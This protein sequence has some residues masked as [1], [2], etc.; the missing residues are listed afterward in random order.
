MLS[1]QNVLSIETGCCPVVSLPVFNEIVISRR[2]VMKELTMSE[3]QEVSGG[4]LET[5]GSAALIGGIGLAK[6]G[7][8]WAS[9]GVAAAFAGSPLV[10]L[11]MAGLAFYA[12]YKL[13]GK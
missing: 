7:S 9:M 6:F 4:E 3:I 5:A 1:Y 12:G 11:A 8:G 13:L 10:V 2:T